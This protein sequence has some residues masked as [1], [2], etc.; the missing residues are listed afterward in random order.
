MNSSILKGFHIL[1]VED[2]ELNMEI[3]ET[4]LSEHGAEVTEAW[5]GKEAVEI[6]KASGPHTFD[7]IV[8]DIMMPE[9]NGHEAAAMIRSMERLDAQTVPIIAMSANSFK[10]DIQRSMDAGMNGHIS[11]PVDPAHLCAALNEYIER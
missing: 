6:F 9:L 1:L 2:N 7:I 3:A 8:M 4:L 11:K 10:D 5:N